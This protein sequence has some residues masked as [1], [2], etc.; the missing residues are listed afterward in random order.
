MLVTR[1]ACCFNEP[2]PA[3]EPHPSPATGVPLEGGPRHLS[4]LTGLRGLAALTVVQ[5]HTAGK[6]DYEWF[7]LH[8]FGPIA[9]FV[10]SGFLLYRPFARWMIGG[11]PRP[12]LWSYT[13]R[14]GARI[15]PAFWVVLVVWMLLYERAVPSGALD[16]IKTLTLVSSLEY[17]GLTPGLE[18]TW[19]MGTELTWYVALPVLALVTHGVLGRRS[20]VASFRGQALLLLASV[21]VASL[22]M[23][24][25]RD[26]Q[27]QDAPMWLPS[28]LYCF[29]LGALVS[30]ALEAER[31][32]VVSLGRTR[33]LLGAPGLLLAATVGLVALCLSPWAGPPG[34]VELSFQERVLRNFFAC[35]LALVLLAAG[36]FSRPVALIPR[37]LTAQWM[38]AAGRWSYGI[39]LWHV[40]LIVLLWEN[41]TFPT[42][43]LGL[44]TWLGV[45]GVASCALGAATWVWVEKPAIAW[46]QQ[47]SP[48]AV[49]ASDA[50]APVAPV[51]PAPVAPAPVA[52]APVVA[53]A[54]LDLAPVDPAPAAGVSF[55]PTPL[56]PAAPETVRRSGKHRAH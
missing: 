37:L 17:F 2:V 9:L 44:V 21:P 29:C 45:V 26:N 10:L 13:V 51:A 34:L 43:P 35:G 42:G 54:P 47:Q 39:Y 20:G 33:R 12:E 6:T 8:A 15:F 30:L 55:D 40:P 31:A 25:A 53:L 32:G 36:L 46:A 11:G 14:R 4:A 19:S 48:P 5:V 7:G 28:Y 52:P 56:A 27:I 49:A 38:Q 50:P 18:Q 16:W 24:Y 41:V 3:P 22:F 23:V 1:R